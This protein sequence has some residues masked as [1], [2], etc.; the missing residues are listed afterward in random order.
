MIA[1][2]TSQNSYTLLQFC[3]SI[4]ITC[5]FAKARVDLGFMN[6]VCCRDNLQMNNQTKMPTLFLV[7]GG[8]FQDIIGNKRDNGI[9][10]VVKHWVCNHKNLGSHPGHGSPL[11]WVWAWWAPTGLGLSLATCPGKF[12]FYPLDAWFME[13]SSTVGWGMIAYTGGPNWSS[14]TKQPFT[15]IFYDNSPGTKHQFCR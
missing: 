2:W 5:Y 4:F 11:L 12:A 9:R 13:L 7:M 1:Y 15:W 6:T 8:Q 14:V 3:W 10:S